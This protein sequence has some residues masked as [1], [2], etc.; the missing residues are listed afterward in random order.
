MNTISIDPEAR[1]KQCL[2]HQRNTFPALER[3]SVEG[4][5]R[6]PSSSPLSVLTPAL[7]I[8]F[9]ASLACS[10]VLSTAAYRNRTRSHAVS[11]S[12]WNHDGATQRHS[13]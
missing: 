11:N 13:Y 4:P 8:P 12:Q 9:K 7:V 1:L 2:Y 3:G 10:D 5:S 6:Q